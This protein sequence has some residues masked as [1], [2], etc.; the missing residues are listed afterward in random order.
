MTN[1][2][3]ARVFTETAPIAPKD[4]RFEEIAQEVFTF[5]V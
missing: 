2:F 4:P 1:L 3:E 5:L